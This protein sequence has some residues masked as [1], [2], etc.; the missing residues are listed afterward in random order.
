M[1]SFESMKPMYCQ[2]FIDKPK[3]AFCIKK[4][5]MRPHKVDLLF[6]IK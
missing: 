2:Y 6:S 5:A 3:H 1:Y 4:F